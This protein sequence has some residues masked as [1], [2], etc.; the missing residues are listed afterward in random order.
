M[1]EWL[2]LLA[3]LGV[4]GRPCILVTLAETRGSVPREAGTKMVVTE[5]QSFGTIGGG[6]LEFEA[7]REAREM[8]ASGAAAAQLRRFGLGPSLGQCCGGSARVLFEP[9]SGQQE[10]WQAALHELAERGAPVVLV[11]AIGTGG[12]KLVVSGE[13]VVGALGDPEGHARAVAAARALLEVADAGV[14]LEEGEDGTALLLEPIRPDGLHVVLFGA[15][16]V[17]KALVRILGELPCRVTWIDSRAEQFPGEVPANVA[18]ECTEMPQYAVDRAPPG[19]AFLVI[20]HNHAL[21]L[22]LCEKILGKN[23]FCYFGLIGSATK[24]AKFIKRLKA[25]G[26]AQDLIDRMI[27]PIG[28]PGLSGKHP[29]EIAVAVA[30]QLLMA[31]VA[32]EPAMGR[33]LAGAAT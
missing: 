1:A 17:G 8:L 12:G 28:I 18:V 4:S 21:D 11:T 3:Q 14:R 27:C 5:D 19:A 9:M 7:L 13:V 24:R 22:R 10:P 30:A 2:S 32:P 6:Q 15:G 20:T 26:I 23:D 29:G 31:R 16:H 33:V 25:R